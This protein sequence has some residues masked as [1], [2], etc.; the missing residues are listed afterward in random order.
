MSL[1]NWIED[2][3][4]FGLQKPPD[5]WLQRLFDYDHRL[6]VLPSRKDRKAYLLAIRR[7]HSVGLG[8]V[9]MIDNKHPDTNMCYVHGLLPIS[10][11]NITG[12]NPF[13]E[14]TSASLIA[15][16]RQRDTWTPQEAGYGEK[17]DYADAVEV[18]EEKKAEKE[19]QELRDKFYHLARDAW[20]SLKARTGQR[21]R[22][23]TDYVGAARLPKRKAG[24]E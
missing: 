12:P 2:E 1:G 4:K 3:N 10:P 8:D 14:Q 19:N 7:L 17:L 16:L 9:A 5:W 11:L 15:A 20:R 24:S 22:R 18:A 21:N 6:V 13:T 23:A